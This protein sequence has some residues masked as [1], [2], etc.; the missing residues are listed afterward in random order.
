MRIAGLALC[1]AL[2]ACGEGDE[3]SRSRDAQSVVAT[4]SDAVVAPWLSPTDGTDPARWLAAR[5]SGSPTP[6]ADSR[7]AHLRRS[8]ARAKTSFIEDPRMIANRTVQLAQMLAE[9]G[10]PE[11]YADLVDGLEAVA[12]A[13][14]RKQLYGEMCQ[15][16]YNTRQ[17]G[18][19]RTAAL[20]TLAEH[21]AGQVELGQK[22]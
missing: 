22:P 18:A 8:L 20:A 19:D 11:S 10:K 15:H 6:G 9:S 16:Y 2:G 7:E 13:T 17:Q 14:R 1:L 12:A 5:E 21:Y 4:T 3:A